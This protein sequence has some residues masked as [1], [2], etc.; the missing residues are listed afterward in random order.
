MELKVIDLAP[1]VGRELI[2]FGLS[3]FS[4]PTEIAASHHHLHKANADPL[5]L[6]LQSHVDLKEPLFL[7]GLE[8]PPHGGV[9][10]RGPTTTR[11][12]VALGHQHV[13]LQEGIA[14]CLVDEFQHDA[15]GDH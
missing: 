15:L 14:Q 12:L 13:E 7:V 2:V 3:D 10:E 11:G 6:A 1:L 8:G 4:T 9:F 5:E